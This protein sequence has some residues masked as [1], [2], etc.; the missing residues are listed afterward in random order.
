MATAEV[1]PPASV[2]ALVK[3]ESMSPEAIFAPGAIDPLLDQIKAEVRAQ[4]PDLTTDKGRKAIASLAYKV[5]RTKTFID[6]GRQKL[7]AEEKKRLAAIDAEGRRIREEL[8]ALRDEVRKPLT[9]WEEAERLRMACHEEAIGF[10][11]GLDNLPVLHSAADIEQRLTCAEEAF[12]RQWEEFSQR[13][14]EIIHRVRMNLGIHL[15][16]AKRHEAEQAELE[17]L[18][19][20]KAEREERDRQEREAREAAERAERESKERAEAEERERQRREEE[21]RQATAEAEERARKAEEAA[22]AAAEQAERDR[23]TRHKL[24]LERLRSFANHATIEMAQSGFVSA[25]AIEQRIATVRDESRDWEEYTIQAGEVRLRVLADLAA[26]LAVAREH[27]RVAA[28]KAAEAERQRIAQQERE[29]LEE[30]RRAEEERQR[31]LEANKR[32]RAKIH[33]EAKA[34]L[35]HFAG[36][37]ED[38]ALAVVRQIADNK[39]PHVAVTY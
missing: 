24:A 31:K 22:K 29:R 17:Q 32:H 27:E 10:L 26:A 36:I 3:V 23:I 39:I 15:E 35:V 13:A 8:D 18:R 16:A 5:S 7:V 11:D 6:E 21:I 4:Q 9:D 12:S 37:T 14:T 20:E 30:E 28:E 33:G 2:S 19:R 1:L 34:A 38:Q 25:A